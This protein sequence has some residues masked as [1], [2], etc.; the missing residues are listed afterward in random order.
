MI[1]EKIDKIQERVYT[2]YRCINCNSLLVKGD[3]KD[4]KIEIKCRKCKRYVIFE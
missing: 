1:G 2:E 3:L 4:G